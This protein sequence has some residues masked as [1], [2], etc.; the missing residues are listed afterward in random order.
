MPIPKV[1]SRQQQ[2][3]FSGALTWNMS[4]ILVNE[5]LPGETLWVGGPN[6]GIDALWDEFE[7]SMTYPSIWILI[8]TMIPSLEHST[9]RRT[10]RYN[11]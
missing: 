5:H 4:G 11:P 6:P 2:I 8:L 1:G 7:D 9:R 3:K 10:G